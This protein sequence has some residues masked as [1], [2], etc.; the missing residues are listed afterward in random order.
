MLP[1]RIAI[2]LFGVVVATTMFGCE[3]PVAPNLNADESTA[4]ALRELLESG[5]GPA[6]EG[7]GATLSEPTGWATLAGRFQINGTA[8]RLGPLKVDKDTEV[9]APAGTRV[10]EE[11]VEV[12]STGGIK[13]V[14]ICLVS[15][16]PAD[17]PKW[18]HPSYLE[19]KTGEVIFDQK[20]CIFLSHVSAMRS[21]QTLRILNS[22]PVLHNT[23]IQAGRGAIAFNGSV[24]SNGETTY[25][26]GG[27]T[28]R[29]FPISCSVH[30]W[31]SAFMIT[32]DS[33][34][35]AVTDDDGGFEIANV[36]AGVEL[37]F[38]VWQQKPGFLQKVS[39]NGA[40]TQ[41]RQGRF[42]IMLTPDERR[43]MSVTVDASVFQ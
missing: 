36:P 8:P 15:K 6:D 37:E 12:S 2:L 43:E 34:Y 41:W 38:R 20:A 29:P 21:T 16:T 13:N 5:A 17:D 35:F 23:N 1:H 39:V 31:M 7:G 18:E 40:A 27:Q 25:Q 14:L 42:S 28:D 30:P 32:R 3:R 24:P 11:T 22:D 33:P 10:M 4:L 26:P 19:G 9:C